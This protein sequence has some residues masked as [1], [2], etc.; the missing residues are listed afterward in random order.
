MRQVLAIDDDP[1]MRAM[2]ADY[3]TEHG[4]AVRTAAAGRDVPRLLA[5]TD[6]SLLLLDVRLDDAD[7]LEVLRDLR[8]RSPLPVIV[9]S[10]HRRDEVDRTLGLELGADDYIT[11]PFAMRELLARI[12]AVL[13]RFDA[14]PPA[15]DRTRARYRFAG[16]ELGLR[17]R[18]LTAPDGADVALTR[19]E[20]S[21]LA[22]FVAAPQQVLSRAQLLAASRVHDQE[23]FDR[24]IDVQILRLRRK[25]ERD[26]SDPQLIRTERGV[27]YVF[28]ATVEAV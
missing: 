6:P 19:G 18:R 20:F 12:R 1:A 21:L 15:Q 2:I 13:R 5:Q 27:G 22:A 14:V 9:M 23:V 17:T 24:S 16:W 7:G 28:T 4:F 25:L 10:G 3:L 26:P 8:S 11:K